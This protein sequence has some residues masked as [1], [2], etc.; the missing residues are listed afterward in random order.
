MNLRPYQRECIHA[1]IAA[2]KAGRRRLLVSLPTGTGK[3]VVFAHLPRALRMKKRMLI[4]A[5]RE[6]LIVQAVDKLRAAD[7]H[8]TIGVEKADHYAGDEASVV[9]ASVATLG[10]VVTSRL[11]RFDP[12]QFSVVV[13]DEAHHAVADSYRRVLEHFGAFAPGATQMVVGFTATPK[14]GDK[15]GLQD[16]FED[17]AFAR[18]LPAMV[19]HGYLCPLRG[20][21][22]TTSVDLDDVR[23]RRGDFVERDLATA[24]DV[25]QRNRVLVEQ[26]EKLAAGRRMIVFCAGVHHAHSVAAA[27]VAAGVPAAAVWGDMAPDERRGA[28][29]AFRDGALRVLTNCNVLSEGFDEPRVEA[30][31][32]ARPT[33]SQLLY[34]QMVGRATRTHPGKVDALVIDVVDSTRRH[35]LV[36]LDHLFGLP[37][38]FDL[39]GANVLDV[40]TRMSALAASFPWIDLSAVTSSAELQVAAERIELFRFD[41]PP[42]ID[43]LCTLSWTRAPGGGYLLALPGRESFRIEQTMLGAW[44]VDY[45]G[46]GATRTTTVATIDEAIDRVEAWV[47]RRRRDVVKLVQRDERWRGRPPTEKQ[48][49]LLESLRL[50]AP[51][52][53]QRGHAAMMIAF[54]S[55]RRR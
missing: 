53:L 46:R 13:V 42:E 12:A 23:T 7:P 43:D 19:R 21:R 48:V 40:Q 38:G 18:T 10:R 51:Q 32:L 9:V 28:L 54:A 33:K 11:R 39:G 4:L 41:P 6:E 45:S 34:A 3:T 55:A 31:M 26:Y 5:H 16:V 44:D 17:I 35:R 30:V 25:A 24:V 52:G 14:R 15:S 20:W 47:E 50:P 22:V 2:Y 27:F 8:L 49:R 1:L 37:A 36:G 29:Q